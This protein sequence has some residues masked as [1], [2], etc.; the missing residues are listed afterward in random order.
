MRERERERDLTATYLQ[1]G[2]H[3]SPLGHL[4]LLKPSALFRPWPP[5]TSARQ[6][7][8]WL[9]RPPALAHSMARPS[10]LV[11]GSLSARSW[12]SLS[13]S[14]CVMGQTIIWQQ[15]KAAPRDHQQADRRRH[16][17]DARTLLLLL[18]IRS[19]HI[20]GP[21]MCNKCAQLLV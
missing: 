2:N 4:T 8:H 7:A 20:G 10:P 6:L 21:Q 19:S 17:L 16:P 3:V 18:R 1:H 12:L 11:A 9:A 15:I 14:L 5:R 13:L